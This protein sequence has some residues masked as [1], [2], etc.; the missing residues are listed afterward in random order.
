M[1]SKLIDRL[2]KLIKNQDPFYTLDFIL[3]TNAD[4]YTIIGKRSNGK[5][6]A[7]KQYCLEDF[8]ENGNKFVYLRRE[9]IDIGPNDIEAYFLDENFS[10]EK[11][12][13]GK[14]TRITAWGG[15]IYAVHEV[16][17]KIDRKDICG[18]AVS[19]ASAKHFKSQYFPRF[20][21]I[22]FEEWLTD[23]GYL[24]NEPNRLMHF[25]STV[26]RLKK[27]KV[28]L[29]GN[30]IDPDCIYFREWQL[31]HVPQQEQGTID[32]YE[33]EVVN[34]N[35]KVILDENG[36]PITVNIAVEMCDNTTTQGKMVFGEV[37]KSINGGKWESR[38]HP[39]LPDDYD[40]YNVHYEMT[41]VNNLLSYKI[42][43]ITHK[44][45]KASAPMLYC[46][47]TKRI[48][49]KRVI[50]KDFSTNRYVSQYL[51]PICAGDKIVIDLIKKKRIVYSDNLTGTQLSNLLPQLI[52]G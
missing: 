34:E 2:A 12:T 44:T 23:D 10:I 31:I 5:T 20:E 19:L 22:I 9:K 11:I 14:Y 41:F 25:V 49:T 30:T 15:M 24:P 38:A 7:V 1:Q 51:Y 52:R 32:I 36:N 45:D 39:H 47:P 3:S 46:Y 8:V 27:I 42:V 6:F 4:Y 29:I 21:N 43:L 16:D 17:G 50:T 18:R 33:V 28:F 26:A 35:G 48:N 40:N 13:K 37:S